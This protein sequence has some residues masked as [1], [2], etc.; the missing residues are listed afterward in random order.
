MLTEM[1]SGREGGSQRGSTLQSVQHMEHLYQRAAHYWGYLSVPGTTA[2]HRA[3][4]GFESALHHTYLQDLCPH[5]LGREDAHF[6]TLFFTALRAPWQMQTLLCPWSPG[7]LVELVTSLLCLSWPV[8]PKWIP[9]HPTGNLNQF[10]WWA[11]PPAASGANTLVWAKRQ[12]LGSVQLGAALN[13]Q[14]HPYSP[15]AHHSTGCKVQEA[16]AISHCGYTWVLPVSSPRA[17]AVQ[18]H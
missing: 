5:R 7:S 15:Q 3:V 6:F 9:G 13:T 17:V 18:Q 2:A 10:S 8:V 16:S 4:P 12:H 11:Q 1:S 14:A